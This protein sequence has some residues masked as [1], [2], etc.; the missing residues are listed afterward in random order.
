MKKK[1]STPAVIAIVLL[2][3]GGAAGLLYYAYQNSGGASGPDM[4]SITSEMKSFDKG[5]PEI[6]EELKKQAHGMGS[7]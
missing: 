6:P 5:N 7:R 1:L 3:A 2:T 4:A